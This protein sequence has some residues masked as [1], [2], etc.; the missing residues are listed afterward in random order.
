M[1]VVDRFEELD[2]G[3]P[4]VL[5]IGAFD[6]VHRGH[7]YLIRQVVTRARAIDAASTV[8]T[9][10]PRPQVVLQ[11]G[12]DQLTD[13][14]AKERIVAALGVDTLV[15]MP[16]SRDTAQIPAGQFLVHMLD[17]VNLA[18]IWL[19][20]DFAFGY[21]RGGNVDFLIRAGQHSGFAVHVVPRQGLAGGTV[22]STRIRELVGEGKVEEAAILLGHYASLRGHVVRGAG[23]GLDLGFPTANIDPVK[24]Q[25]VPATGI[26]AGYLRLDDRRLPAAISVGYNPVF[27]GDH[28]VVE[29]Y[30]LDFEGDLREQAVALDFVARLRDEQN[31][32]SVDALVAQMHRDVA[33]ARLMLEGSEEPGEIM[34]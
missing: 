22:S 2:R 17:H 7:Q 18:E 5:S 30:I 31:F 34:L 15:V 12:E 29:A 28:L 21:K 23:R 33:N 19:G 20:A 13:G 26:Y 32:S 25:L 3:R 24:F 27:G 1:R 6:G 11:P 16:F 4:V 8:V 10:D 9:F 14:T